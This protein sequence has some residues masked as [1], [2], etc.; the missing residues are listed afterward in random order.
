M[1]AIR[2]PW[3]K[4][5][6]EIIKDF[7]PSS[8]NSS[9]ILMPDKSSKSEAEDLV[10]IVKSS[11]SRGQAFFIIASIIYYLEN[12]INSIR[13][14]PIISTAGTITKWLE[15]PTTIAVALKE[16]VY[17]V[18]TVF[19]LFARDSSL[20]KVFK[21]KH[22]F[23][24]AEFVMSAFLVSKKMEELTLDA[25]ASAISK[26]CSSVRIA[27]KD[28]RINSDIINHMFKFILTQF[29]GTSELIGVAESSRR[30]TRPAALVARTIVAGV[31]PI[32]GGKRKRHPN[33]DSDSN[34][35]ASDSDL[36]G[37]VESHDTNERGIREETTK[38]KRGRP[39]KS[40]TVIKNKRSRPM[41]CDKNR[42][43][44]SRNRVGPSNSSRSDALESPGISESTE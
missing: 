10:Q 27:Y 4:L 43:N 11:G 5:I 21:K 29:P 20:A 7:F 13:D 28:I 8:S 15:K 17:M 38:R 37:V 23:S 19:I 31:P 40:E 1:Y 30:D 9:Q 32:S 42:Q 12:N 14:I 39:R 34:S 33:S 6:K 25:L 16:K 26:M 24:P 35:C 18:F 44:S 22:R 41:K 2:G 36:S 3:T